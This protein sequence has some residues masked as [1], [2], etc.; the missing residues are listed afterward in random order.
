MAFACA[1]R[2]RGIALSGMCMISSNAFAALA[3][4]AAASL[5]FAACSSSSERAGG[6]T[7]VNATMATNATATAKIRFQLLPVVS[8]GLL[9]F[10][11]LLPDHMLLGQLCDQWRTVKTGHSACATIL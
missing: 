11:Q 6:V 10:L 5:T 8:A 4:C 9:Q 3:D 2:F 1:S 7:D